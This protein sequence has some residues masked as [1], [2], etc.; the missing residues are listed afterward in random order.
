MYGKQT[1]VKAGTILS[2]A[3]LLNGLTAPL[4]KAATAAPAPA[5]A[6]AAPAATNSGFDFI[7]SPPSI[8]VETVPG[9]PISVDIRIQNGGIAAENVKATIMKFTPQGET[10]L[11]DLRPLEPADEFGNWAT[12]SPTTFTAEPNEWKTVHLTI[13][14]PKSAAFGYY[15]AINFSRVGIAPQKGKT[16]YLASV[17]SLV[18]LDVKSPG[19]VRKVN[20]AE[21][22]TDSHSVE[23]LPVKF[24]VRL[25]NE[26]NTHVGV[27]GE[28]S[29]SKDGNQVGI[30]EV[31][32]AKGYILP[33]TFR[34][35]STSWTDGTPSYKVVKDAVGNTVVGTDGQPAESLSWD[36]FTTSKLRFGKYKARLVTVYN[37]GRGDVSTVAN[38]TFWVIPTRII[39]GAALLVLLIIAGLWGVLGR[40][41]RKRL[42]LKKSSYEARSRHN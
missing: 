42:A 30:V 15:Y 36:N 16:S 32:A 5:A 26:G 38:L 2:V 9:V 24:K 1:L 23:F 39:A 13:T 19:A 37:D 25:R 28:I 14:P 20:V 40:P 12:I 33:K 4:A 11:P 7:I 41:L 27:R 21:F 22:S 6:S 35:F 31:N 29:I 8:A 17:A 3:L 34:E 10:G 18:L